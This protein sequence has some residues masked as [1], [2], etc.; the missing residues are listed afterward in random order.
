M[1]AGLTSFASA[2]SSLP[3]FQRS[4]AS[5]LLP[6][7]SSTSM[8]SASSADRFGFLRSATISADVGAGIIY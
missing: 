7:M 6:S 2:S 8:S 5:I 4:M 1:S 3:I